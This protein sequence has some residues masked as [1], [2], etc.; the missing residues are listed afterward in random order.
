MIFFVSE[1]DLAEKIQRKFD[2]L[3]SKRETDKPFEDE[4]AQTKELVTKFLLLPKVYS[5]REVKLEVDFDGQPFPASKSLC[6]SFNL[7]YGRTIG[8]KIK[9]KKPELK[10]V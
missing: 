7:D 9:I 3:L 8:V 1:D 4:Y 5:G 10:K 6:S 2:E